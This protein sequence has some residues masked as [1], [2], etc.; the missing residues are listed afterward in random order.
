MVA[1]IEEYIFQCKATKIRINKQ[2]V[3]NDVRQIQM[4]ILAYNQI[5]NKN[6]NKDS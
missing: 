6:G 5:I 3:Y 4:L 1:T 2:V